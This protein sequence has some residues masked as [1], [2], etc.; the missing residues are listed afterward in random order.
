MSEDEELR[1]LAES[2]YFIGGCFGGG[3]WS[4][5]FEPPT[6]LALLDRVKAAEAVIA[7]IEKVLADLERD[8]GYGGSACGVCS[9][10][11]PSWDGHSRNCPSALPDRIRTAIQNAR[12]E[13]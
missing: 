13:S 6:V 9:G 3:S 1:A 11:S 2:A 10:H 8:N 5:N 7:E 4:D 12:F